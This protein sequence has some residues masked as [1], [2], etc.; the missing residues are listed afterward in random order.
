MD[1][2]YIYYF[3]AILARIEQDTSQAGEMTRLLL[4][5]KKNNVI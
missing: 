5:E 4:L 2:R 3:V 1:F